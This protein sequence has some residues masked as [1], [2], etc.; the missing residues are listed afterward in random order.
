[1]SSVLCDKESITRS[2]FYKEVVI[3]NILYEALNV[4]QLRIWIFKRWNNE[5]KKLWWICERIRRDK[6]R[7]FNILGK[8]RVTYMI[9]KMR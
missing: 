8:I 9:D 1:M 4:D 6:I 5:I 3:L 2:K 7:K